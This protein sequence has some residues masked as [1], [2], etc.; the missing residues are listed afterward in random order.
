MMMMKRPVKISSRQA[1]VAGRTAFI[2]GR[3][4]PALLSG[5]AYFERRP[6]RGSCARRA[7]ERV[8]WE[9]VDQGHVKLDDKTPITTGYLFQLA[10]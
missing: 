3:L 7:G 10:K 4:F 2:A 1:R 6:R 8:H 5:L 9:P